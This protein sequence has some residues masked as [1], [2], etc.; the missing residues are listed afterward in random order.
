[1][2]ALH[3]E[4]CEHTFHVWAVNCLPCS[5]LAATGMRRATAGTRRSVPC[6]YGTCACTVSLFV[7][8]AGISSVVH[9]GARARARSTHALSDTRRAHT[10]PVTLNFSFSVSFPARSSPPAPPR[11][12]AS[13]L[14]VTGLFVTLRCMQPHVWPLAVVL[15]AHVYT[16]ALQFQRSLAV[17]CWDSSMNMRGVDVPTGVLTH[18][19]VSTYTALFSMAGCLRVWQVCSGLH[20]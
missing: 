18:A 17:C 1:L 9:R 3:A 4:C 11:G 19:V 15:V 10:S 16:L 7:P 12:S 14:L 5:N 2:D 8:C 20:V 6:L 13:F